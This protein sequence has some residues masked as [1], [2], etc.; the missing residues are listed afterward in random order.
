LRKFLRL[1]SSTLLPHLSI[2]A[3]GATIRSKRE[4]VQHVPPKD[5]P[6]ILPISKVA[7]EEIKEDINRNGEKVIMNK[8]K[9]TITGICTDANL[10]IHLI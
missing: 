3:A 8:V 7:N 6:T 5:G 9:K 10:L 2:S 4:I 1:L